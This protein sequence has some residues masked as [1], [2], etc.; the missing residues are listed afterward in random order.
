VLRHKREPFFLYVAFSA[1]HEPL[2][3]LPRFV[4]TSGHG[5]YADA[6]VQTDALVG[7][8]VAALA[9]AGVADHTVIV[10]ASDNGPVVGP[11]VQAH[12][13]P[14][15][16][17]K[18]DVWE[19]GFRSPCLWVWPVS[20]PTGQ[21][22]DT[23]ATAMDVLP[24]CAAI[25]GAPLP[26]ARIDGHDLRPVLEGGPSAYEGFAYYSRGRLGA[27]RGPRFKR[28]FA[29]PDRFEPMEAALYDLVADPGETTDV[30]ADHPAELAELDAFAEEIRGQLGDVLQDRLGRDVRPPGHTT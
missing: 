22:V 10:F 27:V 1:T 11:A 24:T 4:G 28:M 14:F 23:L 20:R 19:G 13:W 6:L 21:V 9:E 18:G 17:G 25:A 5:P 16:G 26:S 12:A 2:S 15:R 30:R 3:V 29:D 8:I 7:R